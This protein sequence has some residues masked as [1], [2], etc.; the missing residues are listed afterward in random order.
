MQKLVLASANPGKLKEFNE[1]LTALG[2]QV[3]PQSEFSVEDAE[4]TGLSFVENAI[5]KARHACKITGLPALA[6]DSGI[7]VDALGGKPGIYSARFAGANADNAS[8]NAKLLKELAG[9]AET[10]RSARYQCVLAFMRH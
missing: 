10:E 8:N 2:Y 5:S 7:E 3:L 4:E 9:V 1:L 6:D